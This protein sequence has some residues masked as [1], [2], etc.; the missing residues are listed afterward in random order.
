MKKII[1]LTTG[2][3]L[4][5]FGSSQL[6]AFSGDYIRGD[7][8]T[9][10]YNTRCRQSKSQ[11]AIFQLGFKALTAVVGKFKDN[12]FPK[13]LQADKI[14]EEMI[15]A[16]KNSQS[17]DKTLKTIDTLVAS[18]QGRNNDALGFLEQDY[19]PRGY[20]VF[21]GGAKSAG[22]GKVVGGSANLVLILIPECST[23]WSKTT[24]KIIKESILDL[25]KIK[26]A[27]NLSG[28]AGKKIGAG[29]GQTR[30]GGGVILD[31]S[32]E[33]QVPSDFLGGIGF[34]VSKSNVFAKIAGSYV[35]TGVSWAGFNYFPFIMG[36]KAFG[37]GQSVS[38]KYGVTSFISLESIYNIVMNLSQTKIAEIN[39]E[40]EQAVAA[41]IKDFVGP[42]EEENSLVPLK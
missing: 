34:T 20:M 10:T 30:F 32:R 40:V 42:S 25:K 16:S 5:V 3:L 28:G 33:L 11:K 37:V 2:I 41:N 35:K 36:G 27:V 17:M 19:V 7:Y 21:A 23:T 6:Q 4:S 26:V 1:L 9:V 15:I 13:G 29:F 24:G 12:L 18:F 31:P 22:I 39:K 8:N 14:L 38:K